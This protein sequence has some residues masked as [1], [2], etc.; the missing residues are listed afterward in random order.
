[1]KDHKGSPFGDEMIA[2]LKA[3]SEAIKAG[4]PLE[5]R[6]TVR[7][8]RLDVTPRTYGPDDVK[9]VR[10]RLGASQP[11]LAKFLGVGVK[12]L[13]KWEQGERPVPTIA[14]RFLDELQD[15]PE[16]WTRRVKFVRKSMP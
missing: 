9:A 16:L 15:S 12:A 5:K 6:F 13:R 2:D 14:A 8:V 3:L 7:T 11:L 1:M 10:A 4:E